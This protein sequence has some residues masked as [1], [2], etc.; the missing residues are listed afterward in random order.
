MRGEAATREN[1]VGHYRGDLA[2]YS[3]LPLDINLVRY[4]Q[5]MHYTAILLSPDSL[6]RTKFTLSSVTCSVLVASAFSR[7]IVESAI[8]QRGSHYRQVVP[9]DDHIESEVGRAQV[10]YALRLV[11]YVV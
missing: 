11:H 5:W 8:F 3:Y 1:I 10:A 6:I 7:Y 9:S 2:C 4:S